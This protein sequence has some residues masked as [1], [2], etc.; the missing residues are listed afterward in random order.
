MFESLG[1]LNEEGRAGEC[2]HSAQGSRGKEWDGVLAFWLV[3]G[4][5]ASLGAPKLEWDLL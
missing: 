1:E 2:S 4:A 5:G 3:P